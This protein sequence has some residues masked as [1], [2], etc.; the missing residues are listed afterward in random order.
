[1]PGQWREITG[2]WLAP[3]QSFPL[4]QTDTAAQ[5]PP[6]TA[7]SISMVASE[8]A[9]GIRRFPAPPLVVAVRILS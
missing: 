5:S 2:S 7:S 1:M 4:T 9:S 3:N 6:A 8:S